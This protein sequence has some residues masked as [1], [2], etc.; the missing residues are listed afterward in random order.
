[1]T[2]SPLD[3]GNFSRVERRVTFVVILVCILGLS[4]VGACTGGTIE[5]WNA[6]KG[7]RV[8]TLVEL[9]DARQARSQAEDRVRGDH[10]WADDV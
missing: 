5:R 10:A 6:S 8:G 4:Y 3:P 1:V 7:S 2:V 9:D